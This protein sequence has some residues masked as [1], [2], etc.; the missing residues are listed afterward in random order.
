MSAD[1]AKTLRHVRI[2]VES[3]QTSENA[4]SA[5]IDALFDCIG[6]LSPKGSTR[7]LADIARYVAQR[8]AVEF[9]TAIELILE[10]LDEAMRLAEVPNE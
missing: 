5:D 3:L 2:L 7:R 1:L 9:E 8:N 6:E 10:K 4:N